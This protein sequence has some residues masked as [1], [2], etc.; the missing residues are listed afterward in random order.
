LDIC[1]PLL[2]SIAGWDAVALGGEAVNFAHFGAVRLSWE[3]HGEVTASS[4]AD[5]DDL[6]C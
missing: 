3:T 4:R 1:I 2:P 6:S 5:I